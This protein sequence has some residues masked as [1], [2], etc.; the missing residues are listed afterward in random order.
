MMKFEIYILQKKTK[1]PKA[2]QD[3]MGEYLKRLSAYA[4]VSLVYKKNASQ[5]EKI[6]KEPGEH[7]FVKAGKDSMQ[8]TEFAQ[9]IN[10]SSVQGISKVHFYIGDLESLNLEIKEFPVSSFTQSGSLTTTILL[11]QIYRAYRILNHQPYHK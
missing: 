11:E 9:W 3:A 1:D 5:V 8:S 4:K 10:E 7:F 6:L 2:Y